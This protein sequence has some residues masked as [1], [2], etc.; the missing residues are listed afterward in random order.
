MPNT[1]IK[2]ANNKNPGMLLPNTLCDIDTTSLTTAFE[3]WIWE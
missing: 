1:G 2:Q 3:E